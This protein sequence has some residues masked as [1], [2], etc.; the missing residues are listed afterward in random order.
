MKT[1]EHEALQ[2]FTATTPETWKDDKGYE[3]QF[4]HLCGAD[5]STHPDAANPLACCGDCGRPTCPDHRVDDDAQ[6]CNAC[7]AVFYGQHTNWNPDDDS[8]RQEPGGLPFGQTYRASV[9]N[10]TDD[11]AG[12]APRR[13]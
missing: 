12:D 8:G 1:T 2:Q 6:R 5:C 11:A 9:K 13:S 7:A 4:C 3:H 10:E